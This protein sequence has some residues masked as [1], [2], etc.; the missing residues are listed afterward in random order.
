MARPRTPEAVIMNP[1]L[2]WLLIHGGDPVEAKVIR[3]SAALAVKQ[4]AAQLS[5]EA[6][7]QIEPVISREIGQAASSL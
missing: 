1:I 7:K 4:L 6:Q 2:L 3:L 5:A